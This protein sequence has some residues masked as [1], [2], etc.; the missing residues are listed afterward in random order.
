M[1]SACQNIF[2]FAFT[3]VQ[4]TNV[5]HK[6]NS[7]PPKG[8]TEPPG[9]GHPPQFGNLCL[10]TMTTIRHHPRMEKFTTLPLVVD[11]QGRHVTVEKKIINLED[12]MARHVVQM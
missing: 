4:N 6:N 9:W 3:F 8:P 5:P 7:C 2:Y 10:N 1:L 12:D 11:L